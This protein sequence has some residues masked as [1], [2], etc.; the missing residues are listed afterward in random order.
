MA[1]AQTLTALE[2]VKPIAKIIPIVGT[3][4]EALVEI[5]IEGC[6]IVEVYIHIIHNSG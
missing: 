6:K 5:I 2:V 3:S 1:L 4:L